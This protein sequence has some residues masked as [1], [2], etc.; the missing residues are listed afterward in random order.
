MICVVLVASGLLLLGLPQ[1]P[2]PSAFHLVA[3][4]Q[5]VYLCPYSS[6]RAPELAGKGWKLQH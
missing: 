4:E 1:N 5:K 6:D 3:H 2:L